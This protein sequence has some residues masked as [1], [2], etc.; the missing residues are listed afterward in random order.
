MNIANILS[1]LRIILVPFFIFFLN[2][3]PLNKTNCLISLLIFILASITDF[4]D[5]F[6]AR[7]KNIVTNLGKFLDP[8]AD[9]I[10]TTA[11]YLC[12]L[13]LKLVSVYV[14]FIILTRE[15]L[16]FLIRLIA[17]KENV[18]IAANFWGKLKTVTQII[19]CITTILYLVVPNIY[20][21]LTYKIFI[22]A[23]TFLTALSGF[24]Y[25]L[26]NKKLLKNSK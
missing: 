14:V 26:E 3:T 10:L 16:V 6:L 1:F 15:F 7:K 19:S 13:D 11:A 17:S 4:F 24:L 23:S 21:F 20:L 12:F 18:V 22:Y 8:L 5:G 9:K 2:Q 25:I